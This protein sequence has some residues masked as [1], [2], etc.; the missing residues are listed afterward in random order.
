MLDEYLLIPT[1]YPSK[2]KKKVNTSVSKTKYPSPKM[3]R[4]S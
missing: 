2:F 4:A 1:K 3:E